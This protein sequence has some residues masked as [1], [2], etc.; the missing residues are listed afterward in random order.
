[1]LGEAHVLPQIVHLVAN[2]LG[3][4]RVP[5]SRHY[6]VKQLIIE[7]DVRLE[8]VSGKGFGPETY[9]GWI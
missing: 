8:L 4:I 5:S 2:V 1:M 3:F 7:I 6:E 9:W